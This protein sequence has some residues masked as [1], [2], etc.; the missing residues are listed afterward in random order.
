MKKILERLSE[1]CI[2]IDLKNLSKEDQEEI[3]KTV[4]ALPTVEKFME[5]SEGKKFLDD[6]S[7][8]IITEYYNKK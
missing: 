5:S 8:S 4:K 1:N 3:I 7:N 6:I 2:K